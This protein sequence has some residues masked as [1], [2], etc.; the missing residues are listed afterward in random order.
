MSHA[1][2]KKINPELV[3]KASLLNL[4]PYIPGKPIQV[5]KKRFGL[6]R[7]V[8]LASNECSVKMP[9]GIRMAVIEAISDVGRYPDGHAR[10]L[11]QELSESLHI[12]IESTMVGNGA[13]ECINMVAQAFLN[14][15]DESIIPD[16]SFDAYRISTEY[17]AGKPVYVPLVNGCIDLD[18]VLQQVTKKT[19]IIWICSPNNPT[20]TV[21]SKHDFDSFLEK[22]PQDILVVLDQAYWEYIISENPANCCDYLETDARVIGIRTFSKVFGLA[23]LR[24]GYLIAHPKVVEIISKVKL[25]FNVNVLAQAAAKAALKETEF[26]TQHLEMTRT[27]REYLIESFKKRGIT[28]NPTETNFIM[29]PLPFSGDQLFEKLLPQG[30]IIRPGS[31]F[32]I[33]NAIRLSIGTPEE[34]RFFLEKFD[35]A[36]EIIKKAN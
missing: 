24:V 31:V 28:V 27:Q 19:K 9:E 17:M 18:N 23:G 33:K 5:I 35:E 21:V 32:G 2:P 20:G 14:S 13:E 36:V 10:E 6:D 4:D 34:N 26:K 29:V 8:K 22:L 12:A 30:V 3:S 11:R 1:A 15:G 16:P 7:V 25:P